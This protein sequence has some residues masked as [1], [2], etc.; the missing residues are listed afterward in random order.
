MEFDKSKVFTAL[1]ADELRPGAVG[2][3]GDSV[4]ALK[5]NKEAGESV[6]LKQVLGEEEVYRF[7]LHNGLFYALFYLSHYLDKAGKASCIA[8][9]LGI[10]SSALLEDWPESA[11]DKAYECIVSGRQA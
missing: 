11:V 3:C 10:G 2:F 9:A 6:F 5:A 8:E 1:N 4:E 7:G